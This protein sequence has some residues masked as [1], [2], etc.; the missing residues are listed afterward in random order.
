M[1]KLFEQ[2]YKNDRFAYITSKSFGGSWFVVTI[3]CLEKPMLI[4]SLQ[5]VRIFIF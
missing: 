1:H 5:K 4:G 2:D 3:I